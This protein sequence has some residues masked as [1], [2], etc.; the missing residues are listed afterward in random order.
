MNNIENKRTN[1]RNLIIVVAMIAILTIGASF[2]YFVDKDAV[3]NHF[4][5]GDIEITVEEPNWNP[6][7][8]ADITPRKEIAKDPLVSNI[9]DNDAFVFMSVKVP[10]ANVVTAEDDGTLVPAKEQDLFSYAV[11]DNWKEIKSEV[12]SL[13]GKMYT[14]YIYAFVGADDKLATLSPNVKTNALFDKVKFANIIEEQ[15]DGD[16][17]DI[18]V[19]TLG[20]QTADLGTDDSLEVFNIIMNQTKAA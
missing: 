9:G 14:E 1:R 20:I 5:V 11:N 2:A 15:V 12:V 19:E 18:I 10:R 16:A 17:L 7:E 13:D 4:T 8:G 6:E 3:T